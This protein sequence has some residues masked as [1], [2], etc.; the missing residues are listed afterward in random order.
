MLCGV[1]VP[2]QKDQVTMNF[3]VIAGIRVYFAVLYSCDMKYYI[4]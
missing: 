1:A 4:K 2:S 3:E